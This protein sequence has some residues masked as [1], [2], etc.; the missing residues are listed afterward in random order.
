MFPFSF[1]PFFK[2]DKS[3]IRQFVNTFD[4]YNIEFVADKDYYLHV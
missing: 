2:S 4:L 3:F 1:K